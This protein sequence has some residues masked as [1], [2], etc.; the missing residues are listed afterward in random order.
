M[1]ETPS[2]GPDLIYEKFDHYAVL[3]MNRPHR[4]NALG[5][6]LR[7][8]TREAVADLEADPNMRVGILTGAGRAFSAGADLKEMNEQNQAREG[9]RNTMG[10]DYQESMPFSRAR[11]PFIA[12]ING[13]CIAGGLERALDCDIRIASSE[14]F[15]GLFEVQRGIM[16]GYAI[17]HLARMLPIG[18]AL[19]IM[20]TADRVSPEDALRMGL[21]R[22]IL[23]PDALM[24]RAIEIAE[25]IAANAPLAVE[26]T[27]F[28]A[29]QWRQLQIDESYRVGQW[30]S[31][32]VLNSEDAKEGPRA[33]VEK[34]PPNWTGR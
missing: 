23:E 4:L 29:H 12:A 13:L 20:L 15:F 18:D 7:R 8:L 2:D 30:V 22:E 24:P 17:H 16:P 14:A 21:I 11:K 25:M 19:Y 31:R 6:D 28:M 1:A 3:T 5:G 26:G 27:K 33:F 9:E 34:R 10:Y 32:T